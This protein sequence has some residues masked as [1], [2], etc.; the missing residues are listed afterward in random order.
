MTDKEMIE[1][2][3]KLHTSVHL[4]NEKCDLTQ[5]FA[6][7]LAA[8]LQELAASVLKAL[9]EPGANDDK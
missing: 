1:Q 4:V 5:Q 9:K 3:E 6:M 7:E 8:S 2:I